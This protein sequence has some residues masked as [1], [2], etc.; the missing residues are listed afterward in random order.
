MCSTWEKKQWWLDEQRTS[1]IDNI[2]QQPLKVLSASISL[3][4]KKAI[5]HR[6]HA[7]L[8]SLRPGLPAGHGPETRDG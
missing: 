7:L 2:R 4:R 6:F 8:L 5:W 3:P 1:L